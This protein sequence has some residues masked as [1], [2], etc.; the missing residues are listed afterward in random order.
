MNAEPLS[1]DV[2]AI[3]RQGTGQAWC[4]T[5][6]AVKLDATV[7]NI[8]NAAQLLLLSQDGW[9]ALWLSCSQC[10]RQGNL[11]TQAPT[12]YGR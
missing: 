7:R 11:L 3:V 8:R 10:G 1:R 9:G 2:A 6:L 4:Y 12:L 5:C